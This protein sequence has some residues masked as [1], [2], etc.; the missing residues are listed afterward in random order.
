MRNSFWY[1]KQFL[2]AIDNDDLS[3]EEKCGA[4]YALCYYAIR[5]EFPPESN[6]MDKMY[7]RANL[8][9]IEGQDAYKQE[10]KDTGSRGGRPS[11]ITDEQIWGAYEELYKELGR[12]PTEQET[13]EKLG[14][15]IKR[16]ATRKA[17]QMRNEHLYESMK[18]VPYKE[19]DFH[20]F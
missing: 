15:G 18:Q 2:D 17:W 10:M 11:A 5:G 8:K 13:I 20:G 4:T 3:Y 9:L 14:G 19:E 6:G 7:V 16:I 1:I 12:Y